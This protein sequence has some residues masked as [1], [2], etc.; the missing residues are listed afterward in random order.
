L[1]DWQ[2]AAG[3]QPAPL[4]AWF[5]R[6][7]A[8]LGLHHRVLRN[9]A[10]SGYLLDP[11]GVAGQYCDSTA[12][13]GW[14]RGLAVTNWKDSGYFDRNAVKDT[15][16]Y[17]SGAALCRGRVMIGLDGQPATVEQKLLR[18]ALFD[19]LPPRRKIRLLSRRPGNDAENRTL[20][21]AAGYRGAVVAG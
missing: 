13:V 14:K 20:Y 21:F 3:W 9:E 1:A 18:A 15:G 7:E 5:L 8:K 4:A 10:N 19:G 16:V 12:K 6:N 2:S 17:P 11:A